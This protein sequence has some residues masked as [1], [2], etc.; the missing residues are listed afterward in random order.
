LSSIAYAEISFIKL[1]TG[2]IER[3]SVLLAQSVFHESTASA[4]HFY[5]IQNNRD[6]YLQ[7][8]KFILIILS[9]W[10]QINVKSKFLGQQ[11]LDAARS[12]VDHNNFVEKTRYISDILQL[13]KNVIGL[14]NIYL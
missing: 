14:I 7:T 10:K 12:A 6:D 1:T 9:W 8:E 11:R 3:Q 2:P 13:K 5:G 4:L